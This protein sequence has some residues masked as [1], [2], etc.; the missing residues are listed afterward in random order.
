MRVRLLALLWALGFAGGALAQAKPVLVGAVLSQ[1]GYLE[2]L[3]RSTRNALQLWAEQVNASG[4]LRGRPVELKLYDDASDA[5]R[6]TSLYE[7]LIKTT[8]PSC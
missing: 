4:G 8:A 5:L 3:G 7:L 2:D 6:N 1:T